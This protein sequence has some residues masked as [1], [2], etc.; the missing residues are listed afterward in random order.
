MQF[1]L[2]YTKIKEA[3]R[4]NPT[5]V[6]Q[7]TNNFL[8]RS[9]AV[10]K[11][12][13]NQ[14]PWRV[15]G[16]GGGSPLLSGNLKKSHEYTLRP[17]ELRIDVNERKSDYARYVHGGTRNMEGRPWLRYAE[18]NS[19]SKINAHAKTLLENIVNDLGK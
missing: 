9:Q 11:Q 19:E 1:E 2:D 7:E 15:G 14:D 13:I 12:N 16:S 4:R 6:R 3:I 8:V 10:L 5:M 17:F 18:Q